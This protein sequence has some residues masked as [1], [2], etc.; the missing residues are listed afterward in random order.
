[1]L[2]IVATLLTISQARSGAF[3]MNAIEYTTTNIKCLMN[4]GYSRIGVMINFN[5]SSIKNKDLF[6]LNIAYIAGS[7]TTDIIL[8]FCTGDYPNSASY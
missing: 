1:M 4:S 7:T 8:S 3:L 5:G 6:N 2:A